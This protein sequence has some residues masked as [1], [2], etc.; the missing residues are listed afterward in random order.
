M[1]DRPDWRCRTK[2]EKERFKEF[3]FSDLALRFVQMG[4]RNDELLTSIGKSPPPAD[5]R[6]KP[7]YQRALDP[8]ELAASAVP[9]IRD[10]F[11]DYW[12]EGRETGRLYR[13]HDPSAEE[14][15]AEFGGVST[16]EV[17]QR[18]KRAKERRPQL[19]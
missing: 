3:I 10:I 8:V 2:E 18:L 14:L 11:E 17:E 6:R 9:L 16:K 12:V 7:L 19:K 1:A 5:R 15:A 13:G 4:G